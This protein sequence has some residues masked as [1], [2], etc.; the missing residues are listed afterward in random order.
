MNDIVESFPSVHL[1]LSIPRQY[2]HAA[3]TRDE[4]AQLLRSSMLRQKEDLAQSETTAREEAASKLTEA[5]TVS[6]EA[7]EEVATS[8]RLREEAAALLGYARDF[9][10]QGMLLDILLQGPP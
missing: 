3:K 2:A 6:V 4:L 7:P 8:N 1:L 10:I 5:S 9:Q